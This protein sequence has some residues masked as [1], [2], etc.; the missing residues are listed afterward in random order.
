MPL[1]VLPMFLRTVDTRNTVFTLTCYSSML[2][3][4]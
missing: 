2:V 4:T 3:C 1:C